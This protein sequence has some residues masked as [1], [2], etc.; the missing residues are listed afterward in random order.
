MS[1]EPAATPPLPSTTRPWRRRGGEQVG[2]GDDVFVLGDLTVGRQQAVLEWAGRTAGNQTPD[3]GQPRRRPP[4]DAL[5]PQPIRPTDADVRDRG[6]G[7]RDPPER[8]QGLS[9]PL[10]LRRGSWPRPVR[11]APTA[12]PRGSAAARPHPRSRAGDP[13]QQGHRSGPCR[14]R[15]LGRD[16]WWISAKSRC[17]WRADRRGETRCRIGQREP[18]VPLHSKDSPCP[19]ASARRAQRHRRRH[20]RARLLHRGKMTGR[21]SSNDY[22][23]FVD[24]VTVLYTRGSGVYSSVAGGSNRFTN[25]T[26]NRAGGARLRRRLRH[27]RPRM[28]RGRIRVHRVPP[29]ARH[30][31]LGR[32]TCL[33]VGCARRE[34][35]PP[36]RRPD[37]SALARLHAAR[38]GAPGP[39][40]EYLAKTTA[41]HGYWID[42]PAIAGAAPQASG[43]N[44]MVGWAPLAEDLSILPG[45]LPRRPTCRPCRVLSRLLRQGG[46]DRRVVL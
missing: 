14:P 28:H 16:A 26:V 38:R 18:R 39:D 33:L 23:S 46:P 36:R 32:Q 9:E 12:R 37:Q 20:C 25:A 43:N 10:P 3:P 1:P 11:R 29:L 7:G 21:D 31:D 22:N 5:L 34:P 2:R 42:G 44:M 19:S 4:A 15:R 24:D 40:R 41:A 6:H 30:D 45:R 17:C 27:P 8:R 13:D 35:D